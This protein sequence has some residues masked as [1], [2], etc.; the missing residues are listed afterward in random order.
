MADTHQM[1]SNGTKN[2]SKARPASQASFRRSQSDHSSSTSISHRPATRQ[3][4]V[5]RPATRQGRV[6]SRQ[7]RPATRQGRISNRQGQQTL[8]TQDE[9][10]K[11]AQPLEAV[12]EEGNE[13]QEVEEKKGPK[14]L[15]LSQFRRVM[16]CDFYLNGVPDNPVEL[17]FMKGVDF[18]ILPQ[19]L[20]KL[21]ELASKKPN[22]NMYLPRGVHYIYDAKT[23]R[24]ITS[25]DQ[26]RNNKMYV[27]SSQN[28][29]QSNV[30]YGQKI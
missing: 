14:K 6:P 23:K 21:Q 7:G 27:I 10:S 26:L 3:G 9:G 30:K 25:V 29:F 12:S 1:M 11:K 17:K 19:M 20:C 22:W 5:G 28:G 15:D 4:L 16:Y 13:Q 8:K 18:T 2:M 24:E